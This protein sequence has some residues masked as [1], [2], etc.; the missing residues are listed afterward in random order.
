MKNKYTG[1]LTADPS[2]R[3]RRRF[4]PLNL[5]QKKHRMG[6]RMRHDAENLRYRM[7]H[8]VGNL[9]HRRSKQTT[10]H[11]IRT[12]D[13]VGYNLRCRQTYDIVN[14][15]HRRTYDIVG[16]AIVGHDL[17]CRTYDVVGL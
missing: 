4:G 11:T 17:R 9:R 12:C 2:K 6:Y 15:R 10:S 13:I 3:E 1:V 7:R 14:L 5:N 8:C 16:H